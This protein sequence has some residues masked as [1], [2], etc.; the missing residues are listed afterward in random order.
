MEEYR[1]PVYALIRTDGAILRVEGGYSIGNI[2]NPSEWTKI[3]EGVGSRYDRAQIEYFPD[4]LYTGDGVPRYRWDGETVTERD[5]VEIEE[6]AMCLADAEDAQREECV[7]NSP[8]TLI[9]SLEEAMCEMDEANEAWKM[10]IETALC[11]LDLGG[12]E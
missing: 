6:E 10:E 12:G 9:A 1:S 2:T 3:D 7:A 5:S 8:H 11:E 4:G